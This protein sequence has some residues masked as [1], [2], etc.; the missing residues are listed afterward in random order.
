[1]HEAWLIPQ[2]QAP[3]V[4]AVMTTRSGGISA[5]PF[6]RMNLRAGL[7]DTAAAV[8]HNQ[9]LLA[10]A[11]GARPVYLNQVHGAGVVRLTPADARDDAA[12]PTADASVTTVLGVAC[13]VQVAD[14]LPVLLAAPQGRAVGAAHAG[15]R[16]LAQGV[17]EA[18]VQAL[19][20]AA[21]CAPA[22]LQ[23]WMGPCIGPQR[24]E[25]GSDVLDAF[26]ATASPA[27]MRRF[28]PQP[29][30]KWLADLP[31]LARDRLRG[32]GVESVA[33]GNWCTVTQPSRFF[34]Y[35]RDGLTG[36]MVA[37]ICRAA[38]VGPREPA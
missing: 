7:G 8:A 25:V 34:S 32:A 4:R 36:R 2:W 29:S 28:T 38:D 37:A 1:M 22:Q 6:D 19:C 11:L 24:F 23:V 9:E 12:V 31:G 13:A 26:G 16:G 35:R 21:G 14:C 18:A 15:W 27:V 5:A 3:G 17:L 33:G 30:G 20:E 10:R